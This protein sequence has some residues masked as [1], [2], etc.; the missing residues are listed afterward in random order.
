MEQVCFA[1]LPALVCQKSLPISVWPVLFFFA[2]HT[3]HEVSRQRLLPSPWALLYSTTRLSPTWS[4]WVL[5]Q[6]LLMLKAC[7]LVSSWDI[8]LTTLLCLM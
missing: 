3:V 7:V 1:H 5:Q 6:N 8:S 4:L 2:H